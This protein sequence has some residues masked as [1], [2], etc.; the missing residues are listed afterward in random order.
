MLL[1]AHLLHVGF[2]SVAKA[3]EVEVISIAVCLSFAGDKSIDIKPLGNVLG[4]LSRE[5][6]LLCP[7]EANPFLSGDLEMLLLMPRLH[8][9][10]SQPSGNEESIII[11]LGEKTK[12]P[13]ERILCGGITINGVPK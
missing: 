12:P 13:A 3:D 5:A 8:N 1:L 10:S 6:I 9:V 2:A 11:H 4:S 7:E